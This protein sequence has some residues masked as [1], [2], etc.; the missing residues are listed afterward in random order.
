MSDLLMQAQSLR[1][2]RHRESK[3]RYRARQREY[4]ESLESRLA[5][6]RT[7]QIA[8]M[9]DIQ[10]AGQ[11]VAH[12]NAR[13]R[14]LIRFMGVED[15][16]VERWLLGD[17]PPD[18]LL[19]AKGAFSLDGLSPAPTGQVQIIGQQVSSKSTQTCASLIERP[20]R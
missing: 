7:Q 19:P 18:T 10:L 1:T 12:D 3:R 2:T 15:V 17:Q 20:K 6:G 14:D 9:K 13:L 4:V 11:K 8:G 16:L 5:D